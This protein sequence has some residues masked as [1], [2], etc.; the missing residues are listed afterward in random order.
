M[1]SFSKKSRER[2]N[3]CHP[4]LREICEELI[5]HKDFVVICGHR[6]E[7]EQNDCFDRGV[8][9]LRFPKSKHN[10]LPS[11]AVDLAPYPINWND[12][13]SFKELSK[14]FKIIAAEK[15]IDVSSGADW[16]SF[17]DYPHYELI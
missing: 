15:G 13:E 10:Q 14:A 8:S 7:A 16:K 6:G 2:L 1:P 5:K 11:L 9:K 4:K 12:I 17:V 3:T